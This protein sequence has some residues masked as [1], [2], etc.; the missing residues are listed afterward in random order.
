MRLTA[1]KLKIRMH[2]IFN[3]N[4]Y[5]DCGWLLANPNLLNE[6]VTKSFGV[7]FYTGYLH[8]VEVVLVNLDER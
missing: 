1:R 7:L 5:D 3:E 8:V 2:F 4:L 6:C